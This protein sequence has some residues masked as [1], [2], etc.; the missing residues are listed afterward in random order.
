MNRRSDPWDTRISSDSPRSP[1]KHDDRGYN[2]LRQES[3]ASVSD[4]LSQPQQVPK[5][6]F[7]QQD[8]GRDAPSY[9]TNMYTQ[10]PA[11]TPMYH[12]VSYSGPTSSHLDRPPH[13]QA[14]PGE[15]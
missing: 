7:S 12:G 9:P 5:D 2:H 10:D 4:M 14:H 6:T 3:G 1:I 13:A 11:P 15:L 8:Y